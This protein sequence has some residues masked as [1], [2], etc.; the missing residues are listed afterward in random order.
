MCIFEIAKDLRVAGFNV[1]LDDVLDLVENLRKEGFVRVIGV[2][3][4]DD[5][6]KA[7]VVALIPSIEEEVALTPETVEEKIGV[8]SLREDI[9]EIFKE[10]AKKELAQPPTPTPLE[11]R[12]VEP[13]QEVQE[14]VS[15]IEIV[16][17]GEMV[18]EKIKFDLE[19]LLTLNEYI[20]NVLIA[21]RDGLPVLQVTRKGI[22]ALDEAKIAA[23]VSVIMAMSSKTAG[24]MGKKDLDNV[25]VKT[26][27][28][29]F[30]LGYINSSY[31]LTFLLESK[32][33][34]G[35]VM[36]DFNGLRRRI[37]KLIEQTISK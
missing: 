29:L 4:P 19:S 31:I 21:T 33:P 22:S 1:S 32:A 20:Q 23:A 17:I 34:M 14:G 2:K 15:P 6:E 13:F 12:P 7:E 27:K 25:I 11:E 5:F 35:L 9:E 16:K 24:D 26:D 18:S 30:V 10:E 28:S 37:A 8:E 36:A 3:N